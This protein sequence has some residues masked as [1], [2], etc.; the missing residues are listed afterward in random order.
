MNKILNFM[1][2]IFKFLSSLFISLFKVIFSIFK[3]IINTFILIFK[4]F[5]K[6]L[7]FVIDKFFT[8]LVALFASIGLG[9]VEVGKFI[10]NI[11]KW[12]Y[13]HFLKAIF[14]EIYLF[15]KSIYKGIIII[16]GYIFVTIPKIIINVLANVVSSIVKKIKVKSIQ[17]KE[18]Y[19]D[20]PKK[21]KNYFKNKYDNLAIVKYYR[22]KR[23][24]ELEILYIDKN[25]KD[26]QRSEKKHTY[27]YL[28]RNRDKKLIKGYFSALSRLDTY[29]YL[30]DEGYE[31]YEIKTSTWIDFF[32]GESKYINNKMESKDLIFWLTQLST[33]IKSGI[34]LTNAVKILTE[35]NKKKKYK[36]VYN[37]IVYE[38]TMGESFSEALRKQGKVFPGLLVNMIKAAEMIGDIEGTLDEMA[39][40]YSEIEDTK[41]SI[42]SAI[43]Y[44]AII[45]V[46][47]IM[48]ITFIMLYIIPQFVGIYESSNIELNPLTQAI[49]NISAFLQSNFVLLIIIVFGVL[50][51][52]IVMFKN[53]KAFRTMMQYFFMHM[54]VVGKMIIYKEITLF[55][56]TFSA[57]NKN[58]VLLTDT[59]EILGKITNNEI[60][61]MIMYDTISNLLRGDKMS[62]SFKNNWAIP[63]LAYYM[64]TTGESTGELATMLEKIAEY[65]QREQKTIAGTIK[66]FVEPIM[67]AL[68][69]VI[70]GVIIISILIPMFGLYTA[71]S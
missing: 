38:L 62:D 11:I 8:F 25:S 46:F 29:S 57:L 53:I 6:G 16:F 60:Y 15:I 50:I 9:V 26:A 56:K 69:A 54:P 70:V 2:N 52:Y 1:K 18:K 32:H 40:Y 49:L 39:E 27:E 7:I 24:R 12:S 10:I 14:M 45:F 19:K 48:V 3:Y 30:L 59:I 41:K 65:Y 22:N 63:T 28:V 51:L 44:P 68:L 61:K 35:Q 34:P 13:D 31:V 43:T 20:F 37:S 21:V 33:Y 17:T 47:S 5:G 64:I 58:N 4:N 71:I 42:I 23:E 36:N 67:I 66:S 55:S